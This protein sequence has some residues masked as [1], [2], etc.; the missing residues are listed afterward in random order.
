MRAFYRLRLHRRP[1][2]SSCGSPSPSV[3]GRTSFLQSLNCFS[4]SPLVTAFERPGNVCAH[5]ASHSCLSHHA[6]T[7]TS[8]GGYKHTT[9]N[10]QRAH[11]G[12][13]ALSYNHFNSHSNDTACS[14]SIPPIAAVSLEW[15][16]HN[17]GLGSATC[18]FVLL[19]PTTLGRSGSTPAIS[20]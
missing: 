8:S 5:R 18:N 10:T 11:R 1:D 19:H 17:A 15:P 12:I 20:P 6:H 16:Y 2:S 7:H 9:Y 13:K 3:G 14:C 4:P